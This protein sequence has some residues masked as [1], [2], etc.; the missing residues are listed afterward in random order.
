[1]VSNVN[2]S[3]HSSEQ[4]TFMKIDLRSPKQSF[5]NLIIVFK[6]FMEFYIQYWFVTKV[7]NY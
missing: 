2:W 5:L 3:T 6:I 7:L 1:M 4:R